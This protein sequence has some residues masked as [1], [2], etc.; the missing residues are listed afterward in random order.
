MGPRA[1]A[2]HFAAAV[3]TGLRDAAAVA[4]ALA[5]T[6]LRA[7]DEHLDAAAVAAVDAGGHLQ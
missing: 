1:V 3:A 7:V 2:E 6:G 4:A 5:A